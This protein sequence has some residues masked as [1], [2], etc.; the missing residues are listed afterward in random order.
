MEERPLPMLAN[1]LDIDR[2][3]RYSHYLMEPKLDGLRM[4]VKRGTH[5]L[6]AWTRAGKDLADKLP[7]EMI[8][9]LM[10]LPLGTII[11]GELGYLLHSDTRWPIF[12]FNRTMRVFG[13]GEGTAQDKIAYN[14]T[15]EQEFMRLPFFFVFDMLQTTGGDITDLVQRDRR[16]LLADALDFDRKY[17]RLPLVL[18][19]FDRP[20]Y[21]KFVTDGGEGVMLKNPQAQYYPGARKANTWYKLKKFN[22]IDVVVIGWKEGQ[23]KYQ[24]TTGAIEFGMYMSR[25]S[26]APVSFGWCAGMDD[27]TRH[28]IVHMHCCEQLLGKVFELR[29][30]GKVGRDGKG[31][32][33]PQFMRW[34]DDKDALECIYRQ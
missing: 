18:S 24:G 6:S 2:V 17:L 16:D 34:R 12:D 20:I 10:K 28:E 5:G 1:Q 3:S 32:R 30:F 23:G 11:D 9:D 4:I 13:S 22:T 29:Y 15:A 27:A 21:E 26:G 19:G 7:E 25:N 33:F 31:Y 8:A 14:R